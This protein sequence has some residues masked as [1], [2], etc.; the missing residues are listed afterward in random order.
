MTQRVSNELEHILKQR[1]VNDRALPAIAD[2]AFG[3]RIR[4][5][6]YIKSAGVSEQVASRDL[7]ELVDL[8][9][10][11]GTGE[12]RGRIYDA[13]PSIREIYVRTYEP[14]TTIDPFS[15]GALP[16]PEDALSGG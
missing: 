1:H 10:L 4:R 7:K 12:T 14:R 8:G 11:T 15:Q 9:L 6:H 3:Y 13:S 5:S 2:A 16:F